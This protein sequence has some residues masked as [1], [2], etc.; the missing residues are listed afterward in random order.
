[1][2]VS[3]WPEDDDTLVPEDVFEESEL[4]ALV[5]YQRR[6]IDFFVEV[7]HIPRH[8]LEWSQNPGYAKHRWDGT[9]EPI[10]AAMEG[11]ANWEN[12]GVESATGTGKTYNLGAAG[13]LWFLGS[14]PNSLVVTLAPKEDQLTANLW[15]ELRKLFPHF[16]R[17]FPGARLID[18][19]LRLRGGLDNTWGATGFVAGV[20]KDEESAQKARGFHAEHALYIFE[21][22]A[23]IHRAIHNAIQFTC[24]AP[25]NLQ[26]K[27]GNP[28]NEQ[29][30][31]H[32]FCLRESTRHIRISAYDHPN[33]VA[34][35]PSIV[36][37]AVS[38]ISIDEV[39]REYGKGS[40]LAN[41][42]TRGIP[43]KESA[44]ALIRW[45]WLEEAA[46]RYSDLRYREGLPAI[47]CDVA[48][49][50][51][52]DKIAIAR[53][54]GACVIELEAFQVGDKVKDASDLGAHLAL[55]IGLEGIDEMHVGVDA[56]GVG[57]ATVNKLKELGIHVV[58]I[59]GGSTKNLDSGVDMDVLRDTKKGVVPVQLYDNLNSKML[60]MLRQDLQ[61]GRIALPYDEELFRQL[62]FRQWE[63][64]K[65]KIVVWS[66]ETVVELLGYSP[67]LADAVVY[68]NYVRHRLPLPVDAPRK[69]A[70]DPDTLSHE[71]KAS[72]RLGRDKRPLP[73]NIDPSIIESL[74]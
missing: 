23:G 12:V 39:N 54:L 34:K 19:E 8:T 49:K 56:V 1:M 40:A 48:D 45:Q 7:L 67:D 61:H 60:W 66:K 38:Q 58:A 57:S 70:F 6:P 65:G 64:R 71:A 32:K 31:L 30:E 26:L 24:T 68:W 44:S 25:H 63:R 51:G 28:D 37:G 13:M 43:P 72:R 36:P 53:G 21:E 52:G 55:E 18:L 16:K 33:V 42:M 2:A 62:T 29:D 35:D 41:A 74:D 5:E 17:R 22:T 10:V 46:A 47:G 9:R 4:V 11:L 3:L 73:R 14:F 27:L 50:A 15:K 20:G 59:N 69:S